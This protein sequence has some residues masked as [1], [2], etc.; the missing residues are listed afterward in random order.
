MACFTHYRELT[1]S[2][3]TP[4]RRSIYRVPRTL[5]TKLGYNF[6]IGLGIQCAEMYTTKYQL[7]LMFIP[8]AEMFLSLRGKNLSTD[9]RYN[10]RA[11]FLGLYGLMDLIFSR[12]CPIC[13]THLF[14]RELTNPDP[15]FPSNSMVCESCRPQLHSR[16][17]EPTIHPP[18]GLSSL[19][20]IWRMEDEVE[21]LIKTYKYKHISALA[22]P[23][24]VSLANYLPSIPAKQ[25]DLIIPVP[26]IPKIE[27]QRHFAHTALICRE[28]SKLIAV[29]TDCTALCSYKKRTRQVETP[30]ANRAKNAATKYYTRKCDLQD[31]RILLVD[32]T[33][34]TGASLSAAALTIRKCGATSVD[35]LTLARSRYYTQNNSAFERELSHS[36]YL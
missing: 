31:M 27:R 20:S 11:M 3:G 7:G 29:P 28:L 1:R 4:S 10:W 22:L 17:P 15:L 30:F 12:T 23:F 5:A 16:L 13:D 21:T 6:I 33:T 19:N 2:R 35:G 24:A 9:A 26:S 8:Y 36:Y 34:T 32:D 18:S 25:W 14:G